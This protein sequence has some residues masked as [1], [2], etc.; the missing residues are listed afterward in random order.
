VIEMRDVKDQP[1][2]VREVG[3]NEEQRG[4]IGAAG[5]GDYDRARREQT[6]LQAEAPNG[7]AD[8]WG[9]R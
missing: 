1:D 6:V 3:Q 8:V 5:D 2:L 9:D 7:I 4:R